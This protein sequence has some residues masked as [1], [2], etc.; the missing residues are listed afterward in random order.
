MP[1]DPGSP[2][3]AALYERRRDEAVRLAEAAEVTIWEA[4]ALG[5]DE[6]VADLVR[7]DPALV[8][9]WSTDGWTPLAL[10][11]FFAPAET[12]RVLLDA[13]GDV[14]AVA[15]NTML[16][17]P[18][19]AAV[20]ARNVEAVRLLLERGADP[21]ARQQV[22]YTPLMGAAG[23]GIDELVSLLLA[24]GADPSAVSEEG[25][26]AVSIAREQG[27]SALADRLK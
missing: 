15:R 20:A 6:R 8:N 10:A 7:A 3:L 18:L 19:H 4:A 1:Q 14:A 27:H 5:D 17:Q 22:G 12:V 2:I 16:V 13:G 26:T 21:N 24:R 11:A 23:S 9:A 25:K